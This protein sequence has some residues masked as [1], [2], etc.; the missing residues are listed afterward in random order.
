MQEVNKFKYLGV[1]I[2]AGNGIEEEVAHRVLDGRKVWR[3]MGNFLEENIISREAKRELFER[4]VIP[5]VVYSSE[6]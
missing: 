5:G 1:M 3:T 4:L 6:M 2:S